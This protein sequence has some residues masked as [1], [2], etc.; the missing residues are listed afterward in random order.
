MEGHFYQ[1]STESHMP[2]CHITHIHSNITQSW[3]QFSDVVGQTMDDVCLHLIISFWEEKS[4]HSLQVVVILKVVIRCLTCVV[5][6][7]RVC[8]FCSWTVFSHLCSQLNTSVC[9]GWTSVPC[10]LKDCLIAPMFAKE[11]KI[12]THC[13]V[14]LVLT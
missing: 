7:V 3:S 8:V 9:F 14:M 13:S 1:I 12:K 10:N 11:L 4:L 5:F 2:Q 6:V